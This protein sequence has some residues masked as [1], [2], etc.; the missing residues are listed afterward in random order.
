[1][2]PQM[3]DFVRFFGY[4][5]LGSPLVSLGRAGLLSMIAL[6]AAANS[7]LTL[8]AQS[9]NRIT[10]VVDTARI[11]A[12]PNHHPL[13]ASQ[14]NDAGALPVDQPLNQFTIVLARSAEQEQA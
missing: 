9:P 6:L 1:M 3:R 5:S 10:K 8:H 11:V 2:R 13:W 12:L 4:E 7:G 14:A